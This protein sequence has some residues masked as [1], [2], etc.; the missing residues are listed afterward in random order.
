MKALVLPVLLFAGSQR[1]S[2][3]FDGRASSSSEETTRDEASFHFQTRPLIITNGDF[4]RF[5]TK[6]MQLY[7]KGEMIYI[8]TKKDTKYMV[9]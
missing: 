8:F 5:T 9:F 2:S 1:D 4:T 6:R 3:S 7:C